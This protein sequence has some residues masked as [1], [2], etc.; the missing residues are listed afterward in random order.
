MRKHPELGEAIAREEGHPEDV[1][2]WIRHHH[3]RLDGTGYPDDLRG[4]G[5]PDGR[6]SSPCSTRTSA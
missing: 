6:G 2:D 1:G 4:R 5:D 3:E